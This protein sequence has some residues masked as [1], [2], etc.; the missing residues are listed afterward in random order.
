MIT[1]E[2]AGL[3]VLRAAEPWAEG[4]SGWQASTR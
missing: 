1:S 2:D 4:V 3:R